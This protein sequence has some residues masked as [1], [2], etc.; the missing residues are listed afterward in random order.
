M[1]RDSSILVSQH[2]ILDG[3]ENQTQIR[4][5]FSG[6]RKA[7]GLNAVT[8]PPSG[9]SRDFADEPKKSRSRWV[10]F[11]YHEMVF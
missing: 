5:F 6:E 7:S 10:F 2:M 1:E 9:V 3:W 11:F 8:R 4:I